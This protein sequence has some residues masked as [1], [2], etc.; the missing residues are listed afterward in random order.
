M[1]DVRK[2][3]L[4]CSYRGDRLR[5]MFRGKRR[6][7]IQFVDHRLVD[8]VPGCGIATAAMHHP[9]TNGSDRPGK[10]WALQG[11]EYERDCG[12][13]GW[14]V[15]A[16]PADRTQGTI[17]SQATASRGNAVRH[18]RAGLQELRFYSEFADFQARRAGIDGE[19]AAY[20]VSRHRRDKA[21]SAVRSD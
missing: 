14:E 17:R 15:S 11:V 19:N 4:E 7:A 20:R 1:W 2:R 16:G 9:V 13:V 18:N 3:C 6:E 8:T 12:I 21:V 5:E 10:P